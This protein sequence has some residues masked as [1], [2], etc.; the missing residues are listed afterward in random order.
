MLGGTL[1]VFDW[2]PV[3]KQEASPQRYDFIRKAYLITVLKADIESIRW[4]S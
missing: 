1:N 4:P 2:F 3:A